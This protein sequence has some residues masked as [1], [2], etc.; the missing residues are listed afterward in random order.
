MKSLASLLLA[1]VSWLQCSHGSKCDALAA[2]VRV[3]VRGTVAANGCQV[4][5]EKHPVLSVRPEHRT[6]H[7]SLKDVLL[8]NGITTVD[9]DL[10]DETDF[11]D[12][13]VVYHNI[14]MSS[15]KSVKLLIGGRPAGLYYIQINDRPEFDFSAVNSSQGL[16]LAESGH[17]VP[18]DIAGT[19]DFKGKAVLL[20]APLRSRAGA[21]RPVWRQ[22][23]GSRLAL[24]Y[25]H[26][27]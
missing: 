24:S 22:L 3:E 15:V 23:D 20:R 11:S 12:L 8:R 14:E 2:P 13:L 10:S 18:Y 9:L 16:V 4:S 26:A 6:A 21:L 5:L 1:A 7:D 17:A 27:F 19:I 25:Y